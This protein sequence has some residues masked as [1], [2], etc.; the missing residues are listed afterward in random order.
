MT[1]TGS[2]TGETLLMFL[3]K[4]VYKSEKNYTLILDGHPTHKTK[5]VQE[6]LKNNIDAL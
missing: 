3:E 2:F 1:Y 5:K 4:L 6:W